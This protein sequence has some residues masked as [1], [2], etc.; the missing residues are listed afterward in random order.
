MCTLTIR[1]LAVSVHPMQAI[2]IIRWVH[3]FVGL[4][5][6]PQCD[7]GTITAVATYMCS[8]D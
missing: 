5:S 3:E 7:A 2:I 1:F 6:D 4:Y 8:S